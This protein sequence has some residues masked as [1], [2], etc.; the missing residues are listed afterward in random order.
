MEAKKK[1]GLGRPSNQLVADAGINYMEYRL[2]RMGA[3][4][5]VG[6]RAKVKVRT[7]M[8]GPCEGGWRARQAD[9]ETTAEVVVLLD[10][11]RIG[12]E[13]VFI[14]PGPVFAHVI[15]ESH[16]AWLRTPGRKGL[17]HKDTT[18]RL[19]LND[20]G[21]IH[22]AGAPPGWLEMYRDRW[23]LLGCSPGPDWRT[24]ALPPGYSPPA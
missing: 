18:H 11:N 1:H 9:E 12:Q 5:W 6:R 17:K 15:R 7:R 16:A 3:A 20:Y 22:V 24:A 21:N 19:L 14:L 8:T 4:G 23:D 13:S 2:N 10:I